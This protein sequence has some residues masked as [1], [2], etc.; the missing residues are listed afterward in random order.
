MWARSDVATRAGAPIA[1]LM[2][3]TCGMCLVVKPSNRLGGFF[4]CDD[5]VR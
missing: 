1:L 2:N 5:S 3:E 4:G